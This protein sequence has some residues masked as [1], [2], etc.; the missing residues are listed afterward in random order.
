MEGA[1]MTASAAD[2]VSKTFM[3]RRGTGPDLVSIAPGRVNLIGDHVDYV[4]GLVLPI[5]IQKNTAIAVGRIPGGSAC[6]IDFLDIEGGIDRRLEIG[7]PMDRSELDYIRGPI[8]QLVDSGLE[9]PALK[10]IVA[11][12]IPMGAGLSSSAALQVAA[13]LGIRSLLNA[14]ATPLEIALEA[15]RSEHAIGTPCGLMDMY[16]SAAAEADHACLID[17]RNNHLEQV[18]LPG[19]RE[20][21]FMITDT[22]VRHDLRDGSYATRRR[23]CEEASRLLQHDMLSDADL[24]ELESTSIE[25]TLRRRAK[26]V[27]TE[28]ARV[29]RFAEAMAHG[30]LDSAGSCMFESHESLRDD[31]E[32]SCPEL[33]LIVEVASS[34]RDR[35]VHGCRMTGGGFGGCTITMCTPDARLELESMIEKRFQAEFGR[36]PLS[37]QSHPASGAHLLSR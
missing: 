24:S 6:S 15:Q 22:G 17:C 7:S 36:V 32:V 11:S 14:P 3:E 5:A 34:M 20:I 8:A 13:L 33:D 31:F 10:I 2:R 35:G 26:H 4:G 28:N 1:E 29:R 27:L 18:P 19:E 25:G 9:I 16:V 21:V 37:M 30:D 12:T 23:E